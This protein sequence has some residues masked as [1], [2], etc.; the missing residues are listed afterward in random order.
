MEADL[1]H[2]PEGRANSA[3][4]LLRFL[5]RP[6][7]FQPEYIFDQV[8]PWCSRNTDASFDSLVQ[9]RMQRCPRCRAPVEKSEGCNQMTCRCGNHFGYVCSAELP[10]QNP[11][12]HFQG[13]DACPL[14]DGQEEGQE[15]MDGEEEEQKENEDEKR[16]KRTVK[17]KRRPKERREG[18]Q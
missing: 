7:E 2:A 3:A 1:S 14:F 9:E 15:E 12:D 13:K 10:R 5:I 4:A 17:K 6:P 16:K 11:Y 18:G 8:T